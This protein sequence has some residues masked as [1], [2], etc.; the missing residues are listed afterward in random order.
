MK[1]IIPLLL[2]FVVVAA[3]EKTVAQEP[4]KSYVEQT[5]IDYEDQ[6]FWTRFTNLKT[7]SL[8]TQK[9]VRL[10]VGQMDIPYHNRLSNRINGSG[11]NGDY[12]KASM[13]EG[14]A[15]FDTTPSIGFMSRVSFWGERF[16]WGANAFMG[17]LRQNLY[18][19]VTTEVIDTSRCDYL[20]VSP[21]LRWNLLRGDFFRFYINVGINL[22]LEHDRDLGWDS[23]AA[24]FFG[25]GYTVGGRFY[26]FAEGNF[27]TYET[28]N[29][30]G[31]GYR[32]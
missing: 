4:Q 23:N 22:S 17:V 19:I 14:R 28:I 2:L 15:C 16:E 21:T 6:S 8:Q 5:E 31:V 24:A 13:K 9:E 10:G 26:F 7:P 3:G 1:R 18:N 32:F 27:G 25:Y 11:M 29:S 20:F 12:N 30:L